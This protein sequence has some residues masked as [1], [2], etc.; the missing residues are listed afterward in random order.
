MLCLAQ[1][2]ASWYL[3]FGNVHTVVRWLLSDETDLDNARLIVDWV[4]SAPWKYRTAFVIGRCR[5]CDQREP[6]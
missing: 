2:R 6:L 5:E 4:L 3:N 1:Q